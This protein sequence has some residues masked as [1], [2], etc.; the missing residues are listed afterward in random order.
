[1]E[2]EDW[3]PFPFP[4]DTDRIFDEGNLSPSFFASP[5]G[6]PALV[7]EPPL[8]R[9]QVVLLDRPIHGKYLSVRK[10]EKGK[11][12][13]GGTAIRVM[14]SN[15]TAQPLEVAIQ[16]KVQDSTAE[17]QLDVIPWAALSTLKLYRL[18][19]AC[20][21]KTDPNGPLIVQPGDSQH[22]FR[23]FSYSN[24][25]YNTAYLLQG[26]PHREFAGYTSKRKPKLNPPGELVFRVVLLLSDDT[27]IG[28]ASQ[29]FTLVNRDGEQ[30][31]RK[32][33]A[34][35]DGEI[36]GTVKQLD[37]LSLQKRKQLKTVLFW[38]EFVD[39]FHDVNCSG[40]QD[41]DGAT[42]IPMGSQVVLR[43]CNPTTLN[44]SVVL[45]NLETSDYVWS[46]KG[47]SWAAHTDR[48]QLVVP[49][50]NDDMVLEVRIF[51]ADTKSFY[52][53]SQ[54]TLIADSKDRF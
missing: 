22:D 3:D 8:A 34:P 9:T 4:E 39:T 37:E 7:A 43:V 36:Q 16:C 12:E 2:S 6:A 54:E 38:F 44:I 32:T 10:E 23:Y 5:T 21:E 48:A 13:L 28:E 25:H 1:M 40:V 53:Y 20:N 46:A 19:L 41:A 14:V 49:S 15:A 52:L 51:D 24:G 18:C 47:N 26:D 42:H 50:L 27:V 35:G 45:K 31:K 30:K 33:S 29:E 17:W 11:P